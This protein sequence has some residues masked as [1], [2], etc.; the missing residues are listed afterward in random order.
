[1]HPQAKIIERR[2]D[3]YPI[4]VKIMTEDGT[5][6]FNTDQRNLFSKNA[7][8]RKDSIERIKKVVQGL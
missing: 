5:V 8:K 7:Q 6:V 2:V 1:V 4:Y 3:V